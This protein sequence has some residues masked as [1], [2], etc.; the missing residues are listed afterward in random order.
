MNPTLT[1]S[2][3]SNC[4]LEH[5]AHRHPWLA[6]GQIVKLLEQTGFNRSRANHSLHSLLE[7]GFIEKHQRYVDTEL[8]YPAPLWLSGLPLPDVATC[9]AIS[10][11]L[12]RTIRSNLRQVAVYQLSPTGAAFFGLSHHA[13][14]SLDTLTASLRLV[15]VYLERYAPFT[16]ERKNWWHIR[17]AHCLPSRHIPA[18]ASIRNG[19]S[20]PLILIAFPPMHAEEIQNAIQQLDDQGVWYEVW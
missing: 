19:L 11:C 5:L 10:M 16:P 12:A 18:I 7:H 3:C 4:L 6:H 17:Q 2:K 15:E 20:D 8:Q 14:P 13:E 1:T 9:S